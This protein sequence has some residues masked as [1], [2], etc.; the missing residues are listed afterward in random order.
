MNENLTAVLARLSKMICIRQEKNY[1]KEINATHEIDQVHGGACYRVN[2]GS[3]GAQASGRG[4]G[5]QR[6]GGVPFWVSP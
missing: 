1:Q 3:R 4:S 2:L 5:A 6:A